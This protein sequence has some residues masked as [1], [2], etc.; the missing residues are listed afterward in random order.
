M[1]VL[2]KQ[3][4]NAAKEADFRSPRDRS[5]REWE[6]SK[7]ANTVTPDGIMFNENK[8]DLPFS[9]QAVEELGTVLPLGPHCRPDR[10]LLSKTLFRKLPAEHPTANRSTRL[11][12]FLA[13][14]LLLGTFSTPLERPALAQGDP[15]ADQRP[16]ALRRRARRAWHH[17]GHAGHSLQG[18]PC[19][20]GQA[21]RRLPITHARPRQRVPDCQLV[22]LDGPGRGRRILGPG[23]GTLRQSRRLRPLERCRPIHGLGNARSGPA[24]EADTAH[25]HGHARFG[26]AEPER[27]GRRHDHRLPDPAPP[28]QHPFRVTNS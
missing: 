25:R 23:P 24:G 20:L 21:E 22:H 16:D 12:L 8:A 15:T 14:L 17:L 27:S 7:H 4:Q 1:R 9:P 13:A 19:Q 26:N 11:V 6:R 3:H 2:T 5:R 18:L 10:P 28:E